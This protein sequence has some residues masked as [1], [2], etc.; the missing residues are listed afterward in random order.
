FDLSDKWKFAANDRPLPPS[1]LFVSRRADKS[2]IDRSL[3]YASAMHKNSS[4]LIANRHAD[5]VVRPRRWLVILPVRRVH[6]DG[7]DV[8]FVEEVVDTCEFIDLPGASLLLE[9]EPQVD[10]RV[11]FRRFVVPIVGE[12]LVDPVCF[13]S[14]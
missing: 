14:A 11:C 13:H 10:Q 4:E 12:Y 6:D 7:T 8:L 5:G 2:S 9:T 1:S 3:S